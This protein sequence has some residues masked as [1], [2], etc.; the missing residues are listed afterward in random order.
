MAGYILK[1]ILY[2]LPTLFLVAVIIFFLIHLIPGDP[3]A[4]MLGTEAT[5]ENVEFVRNALGLDKPL[6]TQFGI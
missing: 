3:V 6:H 4:V 1:R 5:K 2:L